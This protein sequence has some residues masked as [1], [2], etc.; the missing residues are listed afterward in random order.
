MTTYYVGTGGNNANDGLS[1]ANRKLT[2]NGAEDVPIAAGDTVYV[3]P[4]VYR[5][6]LTVDVSGSGGSPISY[7]ADVAGEHTDS[8][9]GIVRITGSADD[10]ANTRA[11]CITASSKSYRTFR[12]FML[13]TTSGDLIDTTSADNWI[14]EDVTFQPSANNIFGVDF[15]GSGQSTNTVRRCL[16]VVLGGGGSGGGV[17]CNHSANVDN[18]AHVIENCIFLGSGSNTGVWT[19]RVGGV[20]IRNSIFIGADFGV[21][22][23]TA[24]TVGQT[25]P[26][27]NCVFY[28]CRFGVHATTSGEITEDYNSFCANDTARTNVSTGANSNTWP[29]IF[30][31]LMLLAGFNLPQFEPWSLSEW[32][33]VRAITGTGTATDDLFGMARPA[34]AAK[35]SWGAVQ[36]TDIQRSTVT[37][38]TGSGSLQMADAGR[39]QFVIPITSTATAFSVNAYLSTAYAGTGPQLV[40]RQPGQ[41]SHTV[42]GSTVTGAW[43]A[44]STSF[45]PAALPPYVIAEIVS[46][47]TATST[48]ASVF[49][50]DLKAS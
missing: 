15:D 24:L 2:L 27:N 9:G 22:I 8:V 10:K 31:P 36:Y 42:T 32:S 34:T 48:S 23:G 43:A 1:W 44:L 21:R 40:I 13:D 17:R 41:S 3:G 45:T 49:W 4:G 50:D 38:N 25:Q 37:V 35:L 12:G 5:E 18:A 30:N 11:S 26:V 46:N 28:G 33:Q 39:R 47:N 7:I 16:F 14:V 6:L 29:P 20:T 19:P